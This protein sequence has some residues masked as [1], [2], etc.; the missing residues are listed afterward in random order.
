MLLIRARLD[1]GGGGGGASNF[2]ASMSYQT[3]QARVLP[4]SDEP[5]TTWVGARGRTLPFQ[6]FMIVAHA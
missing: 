3:F 1:E 4:I 5:V 6:E 2:D